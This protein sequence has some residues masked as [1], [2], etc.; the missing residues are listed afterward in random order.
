DSVEARHAR[1]VVSVAEQLE[2]NEGT[3][4]ESAS[5]VVHSATDVQKN[6]S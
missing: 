2:D 4:P 1:E 6:A 3:M 5:I